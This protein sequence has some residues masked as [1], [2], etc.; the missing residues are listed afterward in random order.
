MKLTHKTHTI[1]KDFD[2]KGI[3]LNIKVTQFLQASDGYTKG[4]YIAVISRG[5]DIRLAVSINLSVDVI[6]GD[7]LDE[8]IKQA[9]LTGI[10][11]IEY[12][13]RL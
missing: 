10:S 4:H 1:S 13:E 8:M 9:K 3:V 6:G 12:E 7:D 2:Y 11:A 5:T